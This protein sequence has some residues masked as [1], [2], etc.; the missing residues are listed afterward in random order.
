MRS[1]FHWFRTA[2]FAVA[3][4]CFAGAL[5]AKSD[6]ETDA[7]F[8]AL[9]A[10]PDAQPRPGGWIIPEQ[11]EPAPENE[12]ELIARLRELKTVGADFNA[13]RHRGTLLAHAI[14]A[15]MD[16]TAIW[17]LRNGADPKQVLWSGERHTTAYDLAQKYRRVAV[18]TVLER[19]YKFKPPKPAASATARAAASASRPLAPA[20]VQA[21]SREQQ[22]IALMDRVL[23]P[24]LIAS[25]AGQREWHEFSATLTN[26]EFAA[27]FKHGADLHK[28]V[29]L[30]QNI[31][32]GLEEA[33]AR[34][35]LEMVRQNA[36]AIADELA[37]SSYI[38]DARAPKVSYTAASHSWPALWRRIDQPLSYAKR[39]D[40]AERVPPALWPDL[41]ASGYARHDAEVTGCLLSK[42]DLADFKRLWPDF[43]R[44]F[45]DARDQAPALV[46]A[47]YR[48]ARWMFPC[49]NSSPSDTAAKLA[50][51]QEQGVSNPVSGLRQSLL[52]DEG[53]PFLPAMAAKFSPSTQA[54]PRL[55]KL[56]PSCKLVLNEGW[57][58]ALINVGDVGS[59]VPAESVQIIETP[60]ENNCG[61]IVSGDTHRGWPTVED[62]FAS[63][64][65]RMGSF[66]G[67]ADPQDSGEIWVEAAG[68]IRSHGHDCNGGCSLRK[69]LDK[70]TGKQ[71]LLNEGLRG[72]TCIQSYVLPDAFEWQVG[73]QGYDLQASG[74]QALIDRLLREQ[75]QEG[76]GGAR[77][78]LECRGIDIPT[79]GGDSAKAGGEDVMASLRG[80]DVIYI[81]ELVDHLGRERREAYRAAIAARDRTLIRELLAKGIPARWTADEI[82]ALGEAEVPLAEKRRRIALLFADAKQLSAALNGSRYV[83]PEALI[84]WLPDEDWGPVLRIIGREP[85]WW[86]DAAASLRGEAEE[87]K[88]PALACSID[89]AQGFLCGGGIQVED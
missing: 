72:P 15:G 61:L 40:L 11:F 75:C 10:M 36:Q 3:L 89:R 4:F 16:R 84:S 65:E 22:A 41:F 47:R 30:V 18:V 64:P 83:L 57:L 78:P 28:L 32:G 14:R 35:P 56:A 55:V 50:F 54:A 77:W 20:V 23:G 60:G 29:R 2:V 48:L 49:H 43:L 13:I 27:V 73:A 58:N 25:E 5:G 81:Q 85:D 59:D 82:V 6:D 74:D 66:P 88:R 7:A 39:P 34:L 68:K 19:K 45:A 79:A 51:L 21:Q 71:Y 26:Q 62:S 38:T 31:D 52:K 86:L 46:L 44:F 12:D 8:A 37:K 80:G 1:N 87:A 17:L 9:L 76:D 69:V 63:G 67:C 24:A 70:Q 53:D 33:L 42:V